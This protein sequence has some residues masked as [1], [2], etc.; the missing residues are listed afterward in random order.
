[1]LH[2]LCLPAAIAAVLLTGAVCGSWTDRWRLSDEAERAS[3]R[4]P[5]VALAVGDWQGEA[6][7][8]D[9]SYFVKAGITTNLVR[10]YK[11]RR[12][13]AVVS[14]LLV[15]GRPGPISAHTPLTCLGETGY[16]RTSGQTKFDAAEP[17]DAGAAAATFW[18]ADFTKYRTAVPVAQRVYWSWRGG[19]G[20]AAW[21]ASDV[22]RTAF[23]SHNTLFKLY[24][25]RLL[26]TADPV[27]DTEP[28]ED[29]L[30]Q[31]LPEVEKVLFIGP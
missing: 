4:L 18:R 25:S 2:K 24:V 20:R 15:C 14:V 7:T 22:P 10:H 12:T 19:L 11:N 3:E 6:S 28:C 5:R 1:M 9:T 17:G 16:E 8:Q 21:D 23:V 27:Q 26:T 29:F 31:F 30:R 13:G